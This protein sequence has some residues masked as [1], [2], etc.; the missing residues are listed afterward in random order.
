M[1]LLCFSISF[2]REPATHPGDISAVVPEFSGSEFEVGRLSSCDDVATRDERSPMGYTSS[3]YH[4]LI[5][6]G[7]ARD[8]WLCIMFHRR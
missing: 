1:G 2:F 4:F 8:N 5:I 6:F 7:N 3:L